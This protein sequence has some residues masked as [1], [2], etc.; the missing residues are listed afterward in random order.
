MINTV[1]K[2]KFLLSAA[3]SFSLI[4]G[5]VLSTAHAESSSGAYMEFITPKGMYTFSGTD[6]RARIFSSEKGRFGDAPKEW[7]DALLQSFW[8]DDFYQPKT[9]HVVQLITTNRVMGEAKR[10]TKAIVR[11]GNNILMYPFSSFKAVSE[12]DY[13]AFLQKRKDLGRLFFG[14]ALGASTLDDVTASLD[15]KA[16]TIDRTYVSEDGLQ[17]TNIEVSSGSLVPSFFEISADKMQFSFIDNTLW[18]I[19]FIITKATGRRIVK[20][21]DPS[22]EYFNNYVDLRDIFR[23]AIGDKYDVYAR[24]QG[25]PNT[26]SAHSSPEFIYHN[27]K[28]W[29]ND[30]DLIVVHTRNNKDE[31]ALPV[32]VVEY[33]HIPTYKRFTQIQEERVADEKRQAMQAEKA[34][35]EKR[36][37]KL[38]SQI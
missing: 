5:S 2:S 33:N 13:D 6:D 28:Y 17:S 27:S 4:G 10:D 20:A 16:I 38:Q 15:E 9:G 31:A 24:P 19:S 25:M 35:K 7:K 30:K 11:A 29:I 8:N 36:D 21:S 18:S 37:K 26:K 22:K 14:F 3:L 1:Q 12:A 32:L 23:S 34:K